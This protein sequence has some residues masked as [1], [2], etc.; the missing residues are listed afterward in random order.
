MANSLSL[1]ESGHVRR[2][3]GYSI[4]QPV[5][6]EWQVRA[7]LTALNPFTYYILPTSHRS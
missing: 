7:S 5:V 2:E 3:K 4:G 1:L 6:K